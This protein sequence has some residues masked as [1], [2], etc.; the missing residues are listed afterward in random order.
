MVERGDEENMVATAKFISWSSRSR[1]S[2]EEVNKGYSSGGDA[3][4]RRSEEVDILLMNCLDMLA[5]GMQKEGEQSLWEVFSCDSSYTIR[6]ISRPVWLGPNSHP[7][8]MF[9]PFSCSRMSKGVR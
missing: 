1:E 2:S 7:A 6:R 5:S 9:A 8:S 3:E 4:E